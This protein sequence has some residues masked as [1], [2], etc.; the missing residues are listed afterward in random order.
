[1]IVGVLLLITCDN[2]AI[3]LITRSLKRRTEIAVR[4]ALGASRARLFAQMMVESLLLCV[5]GGTAGVFIAHLTARYLTQFYAP[6]I[7][8]FAL[9]YEFDWRVVAF[10]VVLSSVATVLCGVAPARQALRTDVVSG[11][12]ASGLVEGSR[13]RSSLIVTQL[14]L[15]T[16][17]L[18]VAVVLSRSLSAPIA[19]DSGFISRGV[20]MTTIG[21][22]SGYTA[23]QRATFLDAVIARLERAPG[24]AAVTAVEAVPLTNNRVIAPLEMRAGDHVAQVYINWVRPAFFRTLGIKL[25]AGRDF[26]A[27]DN[28]SSSPVGIANETLV[29]QYWPGNGLDNV[30]SAVGKRLQTAGG[31]S[32]ELVGVARDAKYESITEPPRAFLY[33]PMAQGDVASPTLLI[34]ATGSDFSGLFALIRARIAE[35]DPDLAPF[36]LVTL[37]D[38]LSLGMMVNR[39]VATLS[40]GMG[41]LALALSVIGIY[42]TM[43]FLGQQ[44]R[45]EIGVRLA[46]GASRREVVSQMT[47]HSMAWAAA[48]ILMGT[49]AGLAAALLLRSRLYGVGIADPIAFVVT[50]LALGCAAYVA[51]YLPARRA[52]RLDPLAAL[53][54]E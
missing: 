13:V 8:P 9:T 38:R 30:E 51:C 40:G 47:R 45:R 44:R 19:P 46:L 29:R 39:T 12:R 20:L 52:A 37:D 22:E 42:G 14:V 11:L 41:V 49:A 17:L 34:K 5:A 1:V 50:P 21:L 53:R 36:N 32:I 27:G 23:T 6:V 33:Q 31:G 10:T 16:P 15:S 43:A 26:T 48:G 18:I 28:A 2:V 35:I 24:L 25:I 3:L 54:E 7:M 4:L